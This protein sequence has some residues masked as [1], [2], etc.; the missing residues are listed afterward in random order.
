MADVKLPAFNS[1]NLESNIQ[2]DP[3]TNS[4]QAY[5]NGGWQQVM[6][7]V[8]AGAQSK[9][10]AGATTPLLAETVPLWAATA[11]TST[12]LATGVM[13]S[14]AIYLSKGMT[15]TNLAW[16][17]STTAA[18]GPPAHAW[19]ALYDTAATPALIGQSTDSTTL[20]W[21][22]D[23][24]KKFPLATPYVVTTTGVYY[25][26]LMVTTT[27]PTLKTTVVHT[28]TTL[29]NA[30]AN[31]QSGAFDR[32]VTSGSSLTDTAPST[33][34]TTTVRGTIPWIGVF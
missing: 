14:T 27:V 23:T 26:S 17:S 16:M 10:L 8:S 30:A 32:C 1:G 22:A 29:D 6:T 34:A 21:A 7:G 5:V 24:L 31:F 28:S 9:G 3:A 11:N 25:A 18:A 19:A 2:L 20:T 12:G 13:L 4:V 15:V 33:I